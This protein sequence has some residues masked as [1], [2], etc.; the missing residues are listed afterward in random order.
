MSATTNPEHLAQLSQKLYD[1][2]VIIESVRRIN[3]EFDDT[4][5]RVIDMLCD[6]G[7]TVFSDAVEILND[8][9]VSHG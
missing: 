1:L 6:R 5:E 3:A 4:G 9:S 2:G 7:L 8:R